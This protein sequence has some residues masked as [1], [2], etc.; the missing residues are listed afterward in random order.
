L[1]LVA[2]VE[3]LFHSMMMTILLLKD[4]VVVVDQVV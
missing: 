3:T 2:V 1:V 4:L